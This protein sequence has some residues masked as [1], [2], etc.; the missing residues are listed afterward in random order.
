[1]EK[2][3]KDIWN[4]LEFL[5]KFLSTV[6]LVAIPIAIKF[7]AD[8]IAQSL[9]RG[10]LVQS[11]ITDLTQTDTQSRRD[12]ALVALDA[13]VPPKK[14]CTLLW[15]WG[16]K[17]VPEKDQVVD[18][19]L[20]L[21]QD[22]VSSSLP[23]TGEPLLESTT[24]KRIIIKRTSEDYYNDKFREISQLQSTSNVDS[25]INPPQN[26]EIQRQAQASEVIRNIQPSPNAD[27]VNQ[28]LS[29][30]RLVYIQ[31]K[32]DISKAEQLRK[33]LEDQGILVPR[34]E[35]VQ[36]INQ[37]DIRYSNAG[38]RQLAELLKTNLQQN[39]SII[40]DQLI[41]LSNVGYNVQ[42]GQFE[43]WLKD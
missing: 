15:I 6:V 12:I 19:S 39:Q 34:I 17:A 21:L 30:I 11:L 14:E 42:T 22:L 1:M 23:R 27:S 24:A 9:E 13:A 2:E 43:V 40:F 29:G 41:D 4:V 25:T 18:V 20:I 10:K 35:Q 36:G 33:Y 26:E 5:N 37:N 31:Y 28:S 38:D 3:S 16:C 8:N 7:G 32:T